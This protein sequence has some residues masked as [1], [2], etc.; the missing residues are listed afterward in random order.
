MNLVTEYSL[1]Y[2]LVCILISGALA[3]FLYFKFPIHFDARKKTYNLLLAS[4]RFVVLFVLTLFLL[5][6]LIKS[7][8]K[9]LEKPIVIVAVD[10]SQ[11]VVTNK[12]SIYNKTEFVKSINDLSAKLGADYQVE[13]IQFGDAIKPFVDSIYFDSKQ[14]DL[15]EVFTDISSRYDNLNIGAVVLAS[16][17]LY[18]KGTNPIYLTEKVNFPI[19]TIALGDTNPQKDIQ[20]KKVKH[21]EIAFIG[22]KFP[23]NIE[24]EA[25]DCRNEK[26]ECTLFQ[27]G[28][29]LFT[30]PI[31]ITENNTYINIPYELQ[32]NE[33]GVQHFVCKVTTLK[34]EITYINNVK[35]FFVE[36]LDGKQKILMVAASPHPDIAA[37]KSGIEA[38]KNYEL[39]T[40]MLS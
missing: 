3:S 8:T 20:V 19:Y 7:I 16:D 15:S 27:N 33:A 24:I 9:R 10:H 23:I 26:A 4:S 39:N 30:K 40:Y 21:N 25:N 28:K 2:I 14:T 5:N 31:S 13:K 32:A 34:N 18:N 6:P 11:S 29:L 36:I 1:W 22:N 17:G 38:N 12:D 37:L 35:D